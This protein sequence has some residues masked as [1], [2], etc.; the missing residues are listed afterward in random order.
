MENKRRQKQIFK[1]GDIFGRLTILSFT[2]T[3][4]RGY[5]L[6]EC[7]CKCGKITFKDSSRLSSGHT[8]SCGCLKEESLIKLANDSKT[9][10]AIH[11]QARRNNRTKLYRTWLNMKDR[12]ENPKN[13]N[14][15]YYGARGIKVCKRW[16]DFSKFYKDMGDKPNDKLTIERINNNSD[17][18]PSNC[19][20]ATRKEQ[21]SNQRKRGSYLKS[22]SLI[23]T[24]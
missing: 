24:E 20:W 4:Y 16:H 13:K 6:W 14:W 12:C 23:A 9:R 3:K 11:G 21:R 19:K 1:P 10:N 17:Y 18:K 15:K 8:Q 7:Q 2:G 5:K 22:N